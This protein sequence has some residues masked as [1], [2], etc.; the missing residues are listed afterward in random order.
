M[1]RRDLI[2]MVLPTALD[3]KSRNFS[4]AEREVAVGGIEVEA[5]CSA[6]GELGGA[7]YKNREAWLSKEKLAV[8]IVCL[9]CRNIFAALNFP[10]T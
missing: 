6:C 3:T 1:T 7:V 8:W 4:V 5:K 10:T 2:L 9:H